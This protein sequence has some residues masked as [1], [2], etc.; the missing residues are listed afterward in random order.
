[1]DFIEIVSKDGVKYNSIVVCD[2]GYSMICYGNNKLF[3][4]LDNRDNVY[5]DEAT[6]TE[7]K[8]ELSFGGIIVDYC[9]IPEYDKLLNEIQ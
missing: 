4:V 1:M 3:T 5:Y 2:T 7:V 9:V 8:G 6:N